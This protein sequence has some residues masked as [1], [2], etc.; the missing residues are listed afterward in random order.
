MSNRAIFPVA[1]MA[2]LLLSGC[3]GGNNVQSS[4][5]SSQTSSLVQSTS[6]ATT[7]G[8]LDIQS[9]ADDVTEKLPEDAFAAMVRIKGDIPLK[10]AQDYSVKEGVIGSDVV[11]GGVAS[12]SFIG[13]TDDNTLLT[14]GREDY[15]K[16]RKEIG[17]YSITDDSYTTL[18]RCTDGFSLNIHAF[19]ERYIVYE[20][21]KSSPFIYVPSGDSESREEFYDGTDDLRWEEAGNT[22]VVFLTAQEEEPFDELHIFDIEQQ[23]DRVIWGAERKECFDTY[24]PDSCVIID[25]KV[26]YTHKTNGCDADRD[27]CCYDISSGELAVFKSNAY[28]CSEYQGG[29][30]YYDPSSDAYMQYRDDTTT[31]LSALDKGVVPYYSGEHFFCSEY[32]TDVTTYKGLL[33][34]ELQDIVEI[35]CSCTLSGISDESGMAV[36]TMKSEPCC[37]FFYDIGENAFVKL[38]DTPVLYEAVAGN[39]ALFFFSD[40]ADGSVGYL[41]VCDDSISSF[42]AELIGVCGEAL[43][44]ISFEE[45]PDYALSEFLYYQVEYGYTALLDGNTYNSYEN[46]E[47]FGLDKQ[48]TEQCEAASDGFY[49]VS[50]GESIG[51]LTCTDAYAEYFINTTYP[52]AAPFGLMSSTVGFDGEIEVAGYIDRYNGD[53]G[54]V[55]DGELHFY[56]DSESW[57]GLPMPYADH[58]YQTYSMKDGGLVYVP[59]RLS[60][61]SVYDYSALDLEH[62]IPQGSTVHVKCVLKDVQFK[63]VNSNFGEYAMSSATVVSVE[64]ID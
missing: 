14:M 55:R 4:K 17:L 62:N 35:Y 57:Q 25:D 40:N 33:N 44:P 53:E 22:T 29:L 39:E 36:W 1:A 16:R 7:T 27:I 51:G 5:S 56:P 52:A 60:L 15:Y 63:Y 20:Y 23:S 10:N 45:R 13:A 26:Y 19:N 28:R 59:F 49:I 21:S 50:K 37:M 43:D 12:D 32:N 58:Y 47:K 64:R 11:F 38:S 24:S 34:G 8:S 3:T 46:P 61:G 54:Y 41:I 18:V 48:C 6:S 42:D 2:A 9:E 31:E 30:V